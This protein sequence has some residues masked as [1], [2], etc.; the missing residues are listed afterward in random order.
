VSAAQ[1]HDPPRLLI[2]FEQGLSGAGATMLEGAGAHLSRRNECAR[3]TPQRQLLRRPGRLVA[4]HRAASSTQRASR[5]NPR[6]GA[7]ALIWIN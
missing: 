7:A 4:I 2:G 1:V 6:N 5:V 3:L